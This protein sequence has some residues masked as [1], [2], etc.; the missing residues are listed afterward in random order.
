MANAAFPA[1]LTGIMTGG[2][3]L[4]GDTI[5]VALIRGYTYSSAHTTMTDVLATGTIATNGTATLQSVTV[6]GGVLDAADVT[7]TS[8]A[9][10]VA[11]HFLIVYKNT[12]NNGTST[13]IL[14]IDTGTGLPI[15]PTG[16]NVTVTWPNTSGK[17][18]QIA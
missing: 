12:G 2:I 9:V 8:V 16:N 14:W 18:F 5:T 1:G 15:Q 7:F 17:I 13:P 4:D 6:A 3:D 10:N 11:N